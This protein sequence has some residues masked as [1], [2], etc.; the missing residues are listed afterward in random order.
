MCVQTLFDTSR[1]T[2]LQEIGEIE[3]SK[4][5]DNVTS[6]AVGQRKG[7]TTVVYAGVNS[8]AK[9]VA[10]GKNAHF[11]VF[12]IESASK[13]KAKVE[14]NKISEISRSTLFSGREKDLYQR[15]TRLS[16]PYPNQP[17]LGAVATGL[18]KDAE[19]I[20]F[21]TSAT[22]PPNSRGSLKSNR[23]AVDVDFIQTGDS[24]YQVAYCNEH[25]IYT[26]T[27]T[28]KPDAE[29]PSC[30]Y[31]IPFSDS[32]ERPTVPKFRA[33]RWLTTDLLLTLTNI[34]Q[35]GGVVLQIFRLPSG[36]GKGHCRII[37]SIRLPSRVKKATGLALANLTPPIS[38]T[39]PQGYTQFVIAVAGHDISLSLF[40][41][42]L[43]AV[44]TVSLVTKIKPF[45]TLKN[46]H[47]LQITGL[48]FSHFIPPSHPVTASTPPQYLKLASVG[49]SNTVVVYTLPLFPVPLS[50]KKGQSKTPRYVVA[51]PSDALT[52]GLGVFGTVLLAV[53]VAVL[54]Q[55]ALE[56]RGAV[57]PV[58]GAGRYIPNHWQEAVGRPYV[59]PKG[60]NHHLGVPPDP[61]STILSSSSS[62]STPSFLSDLQEKASLGTVILHDTET[63]LEARLHDAE[64]GPHDGKSWD[65]LGEEQ[66]GKW[67]ERLKGAG[68]WVEDMGETV[69]KGVLFG[70]IAGAVGNAVAGG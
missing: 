24:T 22:S 14:V 15:I 26:K 43:Q 66:K 31:V 25:E 38:P 53:L 18:A 10:A 3:L 39:S 67:I 30:V 63:E 47:P 59:F 17:Q 62:S 7:K 36:T 32:F 34:S 58:L 64:S 68:H 8:S 44:N 48:A 29:E 37:Q 13:G 57:Q 5:E 16:K 54:V 12:G 41:V 4:D 19:L 56:I 1:S 40:K 6:L 52:F 42:D 65:E 55:S 21:D 2:E 45:R 35:S 20:L 69:L 70:E 61:V 46:V 28:S 9:D 49:M 50:V 23:E 33:L 51:L 11:R 60:Y 27:I